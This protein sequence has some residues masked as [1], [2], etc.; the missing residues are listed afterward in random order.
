MSRGCAYIRQD[1]GCEDC[2]A[3]DI[4]SGVAKVKSLLVSSWSVKQ[5][6]SGGGIACSERQRG[7]RR[8]CHFFFSLLVEL[9]AR[10]PEAPLCGEA[11]QPPPAAPSKSLH[12]DGCSHRP[13]RKWSYKYTQR[14]RNSIRLI[15]HCKRVIWMCARWRKIKQLTRPREGRRAACGAIN[16]SPR[17]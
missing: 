9:A 12:A 3:I 5:T 16:Y 4:V 7:E 10:S 14:H 11:Q 17:N 15:T 2:H 13:N 1:A 8:G 6:P